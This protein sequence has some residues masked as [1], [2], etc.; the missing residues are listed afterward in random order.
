[1]KWS[2]GWVLK[3][4]LFIITLI[5]MNCADVAFRSKAKFPSDKLGPTDVRDT[6]G[7]GDIGDI[8]DIDDIID[9]VDIGEPIDPDDLVPCPQVQGYDFIGVCLV[10]QDSF[11]RDSILD[12]T[13]FHWKKVVL[14]NGNLGGKSVNAKIRH[15]SDLGPIYDGNRAVIFTGRAGWSTHEIYL[16]SNALPFNVED[17]D[18]VYIELHYVPIKLDGKITLTNVTVNGK[19]RRVQEGLRIDICKKSESK[20]GENGGRNSLK[21]IASPKNWDEY[22]QPGKGKNNQIRKYR[23]EDWKIAQQLIDLNNIRDERNNFVF[24]IAASMDEGYINNKQN[25]NLEDGIIID[26]VVVVAI[27]YRDQY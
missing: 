21:K 12:P 19:H 24:K 17:F 10:F 4:F 13:A 26:N 14:D 2:S 15:S 5:S 7:D 20:C 22:R 8:D 23:A 25:K 18:A 9:I 11:E 3:S 16:V 6:D 27:R 1:M